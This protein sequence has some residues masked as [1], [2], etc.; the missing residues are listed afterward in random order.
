M[1]KLILV[2]DKPLPKVD[3]GKWLDANDIFSTSP[4]SKEESR[5]LT[6]EELKTMGRPNSGKYR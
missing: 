3:G 2:K 4:H 5:V 6:P 1:P